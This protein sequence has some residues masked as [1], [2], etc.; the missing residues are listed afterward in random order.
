M[1]ED[2]LAFV[3]ANGMKPEFHQ[4]LSAVRPMVGKH[5]A[6]RVARRSLAYSRVD[7]HPR[8]F[9]TSPP[10]SLPE[11]S[12]QNVVSSVAAHLQTHFVHSKND[13]VKRQNSREDRS[14]LKESL[15]FRSR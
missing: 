9:G 14:L 11:R 10:A 3:V 5:A 15:K 2:D 4:M 7:C 1:Q 13:A 12:P 6:I 8:T